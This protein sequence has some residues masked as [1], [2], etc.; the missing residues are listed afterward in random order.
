MFSSF[1]LI[2]GRFFCV[3]CLPSFIIQLFDWVI[4]NLFQG[5]PPKVEVDLALALKVSS[6]SLIDRYVLCTLCLIYLEM[7]E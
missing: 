7:R 4:S 3:I 1:Q 6:R 5:A 2:D